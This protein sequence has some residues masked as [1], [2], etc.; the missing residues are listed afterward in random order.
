MC[1]IPCSNCD[2]PR[3]QS[4]LNLK[5]ETQPRD[6]YFHSPFPLMVL[7]QDFNPHTVWEVEDRDVVLQWEISEQKAPLSCVVL[8]SVESRDMCF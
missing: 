5:E 1:C 3:L 8:S 7:N 2:H 4:A 6:A